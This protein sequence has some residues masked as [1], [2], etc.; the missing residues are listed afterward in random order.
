M[1]SLDISQGI[2]RKGRFWMHRFR[3]CV[4][5]ELSLAFTKYLSHVFLEGLSCFGL[6]FC[7]YMSRFSPLRAPSGREM[8]CVDLSAIVLCPFCCERC[9]HL[10]VR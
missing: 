10:A 6:P 2:S 7:L 8:C 1:P 9:G 3:E 4:H 5:K